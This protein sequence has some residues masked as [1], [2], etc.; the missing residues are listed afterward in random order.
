MKIFSVEQIREADKFTIKHEPISSID[1]MERAAWAI[2]TWIRNRN[3]ISNFVIFC[4]VGNNGGDGLGVAR[5]LQRFGHLVKVVIVSHSGSQSNDFKIN[6][7]HLKTETEIET[8]EIEINEIKSIDEIPSLEFEMRGAPIIIDALFG[9]GIN[10][11]IEGLLADTINFINKQKFKIISIDVPSGLFCDKSN[12][13]DDVI[14]KAN[15]TL[16]FQFP[17]LSFMF[18]ENDQ[19]IGEFS[20]LDIGL[21]KE[22]ISKTTTLNYIITKEIVKTILKTRNRNT[23][24]GDFGHA[25]IVAGS[26]GKVGAAVL[27]SKACIKNGAGLVTVHVPTCGYD[28]IQT[29][30]PEVMA[31][32]DSENDFISD[33]INLEKCNAIAIGPGIGLEKQTQNVLKLLIQ[34]SLVPIVFDADAINIL[35]EYKTWLSFLPSNCILTPHIKEFERLVGKVSNTEQR[36]KQQIDFSIKYNVF[37]VLKG[38]HTSISTPNGAVYFNSTG[39]PGMATAGSG[40]VLTGIITSLLAQRYSPTQACILGVYLHGLA[41]DFAANKKTEETMIASDIIEHLSDA[42]NFIRDELEPE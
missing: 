3:Q 17:K 14:V 11:P 2:S 42:Y 23:H 12:G 28:I 25:L 29:A 6:Y 30:I 26:K 5:E 7:K 39:N 35:S 27:S 31:D 20:V 36:L 16:T 37:V 10:K 19:Y 9:T 21:S 13:L 32:V 33:N 22:Y 40:D 8:K 15:H 18:P 24:K 1:L 34:N 41:G 38:A 4:G